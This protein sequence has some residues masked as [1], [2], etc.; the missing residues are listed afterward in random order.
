ALGVIS[1]LIVMVFAIYY[2]RFMA[3]ERGGIK[4]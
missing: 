3:A 4:A 1:Y 2:L